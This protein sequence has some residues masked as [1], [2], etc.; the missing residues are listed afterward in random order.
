MVR[1][2]VLVAAAFAA[3]FPS[4]AMRT[5]GKEGEQ[6]ILAVS[7]NGTGPLTGP[8]EATFKG[9]TCKSD[10]SA[11]GWDFKCD[12]C[13]ISDCGQ[14]FWQNTDICKY[15]ENLDFENQS[16]EE[17]A[18]YFWEKILADDTPASGYPNVLSIFQTSMI[19]SFDNHKDE[20]PAGRVKCIHTIGSICPFDL[21]ISHSKYTGLLG[22]GVQKGFIRMG[23]AADYSNGGLTPGLGFKFVRTGVH[24]AGFVAL[25]SLDLGQS[26]NFFKNNMSNH[27]AAPTGVTAVIAKKFN[28]ASRCAP[29]VGL[30]DVAK[31]AQDGTKFDKP[32]F[33]FK[34]FLVPQVTT[35]ETKK[36]PKDVHDEMRAFKVG[37]S[38]FKVYACDAPA[39]DELQ[40][41]EGGLEKACGS[42]SELGDIVTTSQCVTSAYGDAKFHIRHQRIEEDWQLEPSFLSGYD[43]AKACGVDEVSPTPPQNC[44]DMLDTDFDF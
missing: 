13:D 34:L 11:Q 15:S 8:P 25:H 30:S 40:P 44:G 26:W 18:A 21:K 22:P 9:C 43:A 1:G 19:T 28:Q 42:P 3:L 17:K 24:S 27:I 32:R 2:H 6:G 29:Q 4:S 20:M 33:P 5:M 41:T 16:F 23:S 31:Y 12:A 39:G 14:P 7:A 38:L 36:T 10:C 35:P 37:T